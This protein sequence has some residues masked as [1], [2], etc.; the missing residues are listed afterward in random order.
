MPSVVAADIPR[1]NVGNFCSARN[2]RPAPGAEDI[3]TPGINVDGEAAGIDTCHVRFNLSD[4][5]CVRVDG[6]K[7]DKDG[8]SSREG[9]LEFDT[10]LPRRLPRPGLN[11]VERADQE[12]R[13]IG[14]IF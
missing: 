13:P 12:T 3:I 5:A 4:L 11:S 1:V 7:P 6:I 14:R 9:G 2:P 10:L 8:R